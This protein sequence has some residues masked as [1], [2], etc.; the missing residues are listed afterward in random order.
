MAN[1]LSRLICTRG[2]TIFNEERAERLESLE[3]AHERSNLLKTDNVNDRAH[4]CFCL[5][6]GSN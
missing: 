2:R 3:Q 6:A 1:D 5:F 4:D